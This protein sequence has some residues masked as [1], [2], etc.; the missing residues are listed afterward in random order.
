MF[1][2]YLFLYNNNKKNLILNPTMKEYFHISITRNENIIP[3][4]DDNNLN[5]S[6]MKSVYYNNITLNSENLSKEFKDSDLLNSTNCNKF[7]ISPNLSK[8]S[9]IP[10]P[11]FSSIR[12]FENS[13]N[14]KQKAFQKKNKVKL[15]DSPIKSATKYSYNYPKD[16]KYC[17]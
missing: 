13:L 9:P 7:S 12:K 15:H 5:R 8:I 2:Y 10:K 14:Y 6:P 17:K 16:I 11:D 4:L 3:D 1:I